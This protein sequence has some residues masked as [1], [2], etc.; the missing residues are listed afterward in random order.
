MG[1]FPPLIG[2]N[3][4]NLFIYAVDKAREREDPE[5]STFGQISYS[6]PEFTP[7]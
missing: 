2:R 4:E 7:E 1:P 5:P 3:D 6:G